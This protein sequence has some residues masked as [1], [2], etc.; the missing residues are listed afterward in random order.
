MSNNKTN[1][2]IY[3]FILIAHFSFLF[4]KIKFALNKEQQKINHY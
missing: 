4:F 1:S 2:P 3:S